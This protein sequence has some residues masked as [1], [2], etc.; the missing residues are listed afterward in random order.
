M[1]KSELYE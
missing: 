1:T